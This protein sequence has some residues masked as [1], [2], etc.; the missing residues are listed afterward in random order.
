MTTTTSVQKT[1][2]LD[3]DD[4][5]RIYD[6]EGLHLTSALGV[7]WITEEES[8]NDTVLLPGDS[9]RLEKPGLALVQAHRGARV[10]IELPAG[11]PA[12][13]RL[14][15]ASAIAA[16][17]RR[18][19]FP[20]RRQASV[21]RWTRAVAVAIGRALAAAAAKWSYRMWHARDGSARA[22]PFPYY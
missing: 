16:I 1:V 14:E 3:R 12:P 11:T 18:I 19:A 10:V 15:L 5:L 22:H 20:T 8:A 17:G 13:R 21:A 6:G 9:H 2:A 7:L 4:L